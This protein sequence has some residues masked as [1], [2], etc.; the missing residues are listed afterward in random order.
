MVDGDRNPYDSPSTGSGSTVA[1]TNARSSLNIV[2]VAVSVFVL[3]TAVLVLAWPDDWAIHTPLA[4]L[5][6]PW[7]AIRLGS[8]MGVFG[9]AG[10]LVFAGLSAPS[11]FKRSP[12]RIAMLFGAFASWAIVG[13]FAGQ[14][15][16]A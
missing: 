7:L 2:T 16:W 5:F 6:G 15:L 11:C 1:H 4:A 9:I 14:L 10:L 8:E 3:A 13:A 12:A